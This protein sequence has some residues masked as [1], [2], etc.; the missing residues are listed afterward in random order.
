[1]PLLRLEKDGIFIILSSSSTR[2]L[3]ARRRDQ[4]RSRWVNFPRSRCAR[5]STSRN[6]GK[7]DLKGRLMGRVCG[8]SPVLIRLRIGVQMDYPVPRRRRIGW[9][10]SWAEIRPVTVL[11]CTTTYLFRTAIPC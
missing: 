10:F 3:P 9:I 5:Q 6:A 1:M 2:M 8:R 4:E 11:L 7:G